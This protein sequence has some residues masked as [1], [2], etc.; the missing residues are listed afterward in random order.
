MSSSADRAREGATANDWLAGGGEMGARLRAFDW[1][2]SPL[3]PVASWPQ[4]L[5]TCLRI[6]LTSQQ[7]MFVWWGEQLINLYNDAYKAIVGGKHPEAL[8]Q[9]ASVVWRE[10]WDQV[11][12]RAASAMRNNTGTYDEALLLI[13]ERHGYQ[14]ETYYT[15]SYSPVPNDEGGIGGIICA[16]TDDTQRIIGERQLS[17]LRDLAAQTANART[18]P[19][20]CARSAAALAT[21]PTD[22][23]FAVLYLAS[24]DR[25]Q[26]TLALASGIAPGHDAAPAA[27]ARGEACL[28]PLFETLRDHTMRVIDIERGFGQLPMGAWPRPPRQAA[29][30]PLSTSGETG[31]T[32]VLVVGLNPFRLFDERYRGFVDLV[33][34]QIG[35]SIANAEAYEQER[36]RAEALAEIDRAKTAFFS[37]VSHEFRTPL[38]LIL[39]PMEDA[40][41]RAEPLGGGDLDTAYRNALRLL[42]LVNS[43]LDFARIEAGRVQASYQPTDLSTFTVELA[44]AF[45]SAIERAGMRLRIDC[46]PL[47]E[48]LFVDREMWEKIVLNL[49]SNAFKFTFEGEIAVALRWCDDHV[50]LTV[51]DTGT[52]IPAPELPRLFE[53]FHRV[54]GARSRSFEGSGI[55]LALVQELVK[56]HGATI[57]VASRVGQG[58]TFTV[59]LPAGTAHLPAERV[60]ASPALASTALGAAPYVEE[61]L[62][63]LPASST[64]AAVPALQARAGLPVPATAADLRVRVLVADDNADMR[65]Y[66]RRLL[67]TRWAVETV[68]N[69]QAALEAA[70]RQRPDVVITDVMMPELDGF[71][72]LREL[73]ADANTSSVPVIVLS[74]RAGEEARVEGLSRGAND[75]VTKPFS[76]RELIVR[77]EAQLQIAR[78]QQS[79]RAGLHSFFMEAPAAIAV[80]RGPHLVFQLANSGYYQIIGKRDILG[81]PGRE[82]LPEL[83]QQGVWDIFDTIYRTGQTVAYSEFPAM[84]DRRGDGV[85]E[86]AYFNWVAQA[87]HDPSGAVDGIMLFA[88]EITSQVAARRR[89]EQAMAERAQLLQSEQQARLEAESANRTKDEF[90]AMLGHELRNPLAPITTALHLLRLRSGD[91][92]ARE[93]TV[94]ERQVNHLVRLVDD[95][96]DVSR[97]TRGKVELKKQRVPLSEVI[98]KAIEMTSPLLEQRSH[99]LELRVQSNG[100]SVDADPTR[101][102]QV[103]ANLL[104]NAAKYTEPGGQ[105]IVSAER[106]ASEVVLRVRDNGVGISPEILPRVFELFTQERQSLARSQGGL[107]LGLAIV[108]SLVAQHGGSVSASSDGRGRGSE[109]VVRLPAAGDQGVERS[110]A[111]APLAPEPTG[112]QGRVLI[113]D[114]NE[115]A[116]NLLSDALEELGYTTRV[117]HDGVSALRLAEE[118]EPEV[119]LLDI[120]LPVMDGYELARRIRSR[121]SPPPKLVA[122]TGYGQQSDRGQSREAGFD[123]HLVKPVDLLKVQALL[124]R[125]LAP[126]G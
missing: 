110:A 3:G 12:P 82:A 53:R 37:N 118:F 123:E 92:G 122:V 32:G 83:T 74:A 59:R 107:G 121:P 48:P 28:W 96:L 84:I 39:G 54:E 29:V 117:A 97:I 104:A 106:A 56:M 52:G 89:L 45:R 72:L 15:F 55:G 41:A 27:L 49:L 75:Y 20:A 81:R 2:R 114:D 35:G 62:R 86:Q 40:L 9:P 63:W 21:N 78:I 58:T 124:K 126:T 30:I 19:E 112:Q 26:L 93:R 44:S 105:I 90:L 47:P 16:N 25:E 70:R 4:S 24:P 46:P 61:A 11:G 42:K 109:F 13:M 103:V 17:L 36:R 77:V 113:V 102:E 119:A 43:L 73:R 101:L 10:I 65:D 99:H 34:R 98:A 38:T 5:K 100:L 111:T 94:I 95:L 8:G 67:E 80:M 31:Q 116:A 1:A 33:T 22:L 6:I 125:L 66:L 18:S 51:R 50:E 108:R 64:A 23:P 7:P 57:E 79:E 91:V 71:G 120:G 68:A 60:G 76:A 87:T 88:V 69:G 85:L 14:E 115:D